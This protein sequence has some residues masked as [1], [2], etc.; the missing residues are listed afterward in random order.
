MRATEPN[1]SY[2]GLKI[3]EILSIIMK[4]FIILNHKALKFLRKKNIFLVLIL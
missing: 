1:E 2:N 3:S 4:D